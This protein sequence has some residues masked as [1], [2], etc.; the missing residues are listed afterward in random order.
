MLPKSRT[1][2]TQD[3][4]QI[5]CDGRYSYVGLGH[6]LPNRVVDHGTYAWPRLSTSSSSS[7]QSRQSRD[8]QTDEMLRCNEE[9][10]QYIISM[11]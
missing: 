10:M 5:K 7:S 8:D 2:D 9:W 3:R 4:H 11:I 6:I 1:E